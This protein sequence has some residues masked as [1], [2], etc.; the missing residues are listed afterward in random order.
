VQ[1]KTSH[2]NQNFEKFQTISCKIAE[3]R[4]SVRSFELHP[5]IAH[6][7]YFDGNDD[8]ISGKTL[9]FSNDN[10]FE[11]V[12]NGCYDGL[13][14][15]AT[16][17]ISTP[18]FY[19]YQTNDHFFKHRA[20][21]LF[22]ALSTDRKFEHSIYDR[23]E[24]PISELHKSDFEINSYVFTQHESPELQAALSKKGKPEEWMNLLKVS[25]R[26]S[27]QWGDAG[28]LTFVIHKSDL[29]KKDFSNIFCTMESS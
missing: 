7:I 29:L 6:V 14:V 20:K 23:F 17:T 28:D 21:E 5:K 27:F 16:E 15:T 1:F 4:H 19:A 10:Y 12:G 13:R 24:A 3:K 22:A 18:S 25:S 8:L 9:H 11:M 2:G 26:G